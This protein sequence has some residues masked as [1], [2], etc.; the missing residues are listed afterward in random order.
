MAP[1]YPAAR[2]AA[3]VGP[4][5]TAAWAGPLAAERREV[6]AEASSA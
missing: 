4:G 3:A 6:G 2:D 5:G 1:R